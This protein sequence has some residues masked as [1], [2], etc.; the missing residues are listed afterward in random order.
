MDEGQPI[1]KE[2]AIIETTSNNNN[3][4]DKMLCETDQFE[5]YRLTEANNHI[6]IIFK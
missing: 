4:N 3:H 2:E 5:G 1:V 6:P